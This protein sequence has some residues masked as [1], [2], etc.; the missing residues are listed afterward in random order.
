MFNDDGGIYTRID[1]FDQQATYL[2]AGTCKVV[3]SSSY[4][5]ADNQV[6]YKGWSNCGSDS[7]QTALPNSQRNRGCTPCPRCNG[8]TYYTG[9]CY[10]SGATSYNNAQCPAC[11]VGKVEPVTSSGNHRR[12]ACTKTCN[13]RGEF[14]PLTGQTACFPDLCQYTDTWA[15]NH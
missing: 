5:D 14:M 2:A 7:Y 3:P 11:A 10:S 12:T 1:T 6:A 4:T 13:G 8:A 15:S 9:T